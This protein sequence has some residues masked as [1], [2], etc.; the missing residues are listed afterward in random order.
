MAEVLYVALSIIGCLLIIGYGTWLFAVR[1]KAKD[2]PAKSFGEWLKHIF[3][4]VMGL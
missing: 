1:L 4:G 2:K 3:E